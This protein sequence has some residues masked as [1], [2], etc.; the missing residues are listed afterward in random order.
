M[1]VETLQKRFERFS[2]QP[3]VV[4]RAKVYN[5]YEMAIRMV[6]FFLLIHRSNP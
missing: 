2:G 5:N 3:I 1:P 4:Y 6:V